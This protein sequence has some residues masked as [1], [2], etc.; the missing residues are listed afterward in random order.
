MRSCHRLLVAPLLAVFTACAAADSTAPELDAT[1]LHAGLVTTDATSYVLREQGGGLAFDIGITIRN[2]TSRRMYIVN[3]HQIIAPSLRK[4]VGEEWVTWWSG[5]TPLCLSS[6]IIIE[7][8]ASYQRT[9]TIWGALPDRNAAPAWEGYDVPGTYRL[10]LH[11]LVH[12]YDHDR[13]GFGDPVDDLL[14]TSNEFVLTR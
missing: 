6:P 12:A 7:A 1:G 8:G 4:Q 5:V 9:L 14:A 10:V 11:Q 2:P 13:Q 3:C